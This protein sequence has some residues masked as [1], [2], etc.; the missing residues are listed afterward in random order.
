MEEL[1]D[2]WVEYETVTPLVVP[3]PCSA[4]GVLTVTVYLDVLVDGFIRT[5]SEAQSP[6]ILTVRGTTINSKCQ[7]GNQALITC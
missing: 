7:L 5:V 3:Q 6:F 2:D 4:K 1:N